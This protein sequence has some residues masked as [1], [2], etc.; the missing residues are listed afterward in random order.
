MR[1]ID[2]TDGNIVAIIQRNHSSIYLY[3]IVYIY[4]MLR[5][6]SNRGRF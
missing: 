3:D 4:L 1:Y 2:I 5:G 6:L